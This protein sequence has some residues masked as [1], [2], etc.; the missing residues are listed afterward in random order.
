MRSCVMLQRVA[1]LRE[2]VLHAILLDLH[3]AYYAL[4]RYRCLEIMEG[5]GVGTRALRL[6]RRYWGRMEMVAWEGGYY[7]EPFRGE[8]GVTQGNPMSPT[9][10]NMVVDVVVRH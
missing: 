7:G 1:A 9:I 4:D 5:Y 8:R 3:K 10:F 2:A 6:L